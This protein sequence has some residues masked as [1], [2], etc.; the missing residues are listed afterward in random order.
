MKSLVLTIGDRQPQ[1]P[2]SAWLAP[3]ASVIG[4]VVLGENTSVFYSA[5][6]RGDSDEIV[7]GDGTNLQDGVV[8]H[9]DEGVPTRIGRDV[10][11]GHNAVVHGCTVGDGALIG[12]SATVMN[13]AVIGDGSMVAAGALVTPGKVFGSGVLIAGVPAREVRPLTEAEREHLVWNAAHYRELAAAH[14]EALSA[15][16]Q[17]RG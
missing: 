13:N 8:V 15:P 12:M 5:V 6:V 17:D 11:V 16:D 7:I 3:G 2:A 10:S 9:V 14:R 1:V 4:S